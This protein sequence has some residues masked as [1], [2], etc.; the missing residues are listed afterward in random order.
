MTGASHRNAA[1][2][3]RE[4]LDGLGF[5]HLGRN[6][7]IHSSCVLVNCQNMT[8]GDEVRIDPF[9][10]LSASGGIEI[11]RHVHIA[12]QCVLMGSAPISL[13]DFA[14][15]SHGVRL[16]SAA[17]DFVGGALIGPTVPDAFRNVDARPIRLARHAVIG[18]G[19]LV[20]PGAVLEEGATVG[21]LSLVKGRLDAW[22]VHAGCPTRRIAARDRAG[23]LDAE[24]RFLASLDPALHP[25]LAAG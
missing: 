20:L 9:C 12:S 23:V 17:D 24:R 1:F 19:S 5:A 10:L 8:I 22:A 11:G 7:R 14:G 25:A 13:A 3:P 21:A 18:A 2:L 16:L 15:L 4:E 6:V